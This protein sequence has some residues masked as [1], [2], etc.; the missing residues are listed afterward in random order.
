M[1]VFALYALFLIESIIAYLIHKK[2]RKS[3]C[4][5]LG[6]VICLWKVRSGY[7]PCKNN[8][9]NTNHH[10]LILLSLLYANYNSRPLKKN[11]YIINDL[12]I[13]CI[14]NFKENR[15]LP[16]HCILISNILDYSYSLFCLRKACF[17]STWI[18]K[19]TFS[20]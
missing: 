2:T 10:A 19:S 3:I 7:N 1:Y 13:F 6:L 16:L 9:K 12:D 20:L 17:G 4:Y 5:R 18:L 11:V 14:N 8:L 15:R